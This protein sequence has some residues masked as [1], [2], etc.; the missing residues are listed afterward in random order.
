MRHF[1]AGNRVTLLTT[2][3][4][5]FP[6][7]LA[8]IQTARQEILLETY[9]FRID[10]STEPIALA[11]I[12]AAERGVSV[13]ILV[14]GFGSR[15]F[16]A[17][18]IERLRAAGVDFRFFRLARHWIIPRRNRLRRLHR[19]LAVIDG[20][21]A[22]AGGIN[23]HD[24]C[25][26]AL[27]GYAPRYD[28]AV[29]IEGPLVDAVSLTMRKLWR[30]LA[31]LHGDGWPV[32]AGP[33]SNP[34]PVGVMAARLVVRDNLRHRLSIE[35]EYLRQCHLARH[36]ILIDNAYFLPGIR[37]RRDMIQAVERGVRVRLLLQGRPDHPVMQWAT[38]SLYGQFLRAG[39]EIHEYRAGHMHA[40]VAVVDTRWATVGSSNIDPFSLGLAREANVVVDHY[41]FARE[42]QSSIL[43]RLRED[44]LRILPQMVVRAR[45]WEKW[46]AWTCY[47]IARFAINL[48]GLGEYYS[49]E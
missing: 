8:D 6:A 17:D 35:N 32:L 44:S 49:K 43:K 11:L 25:D 10:V 27:P 14:D 5:F 23:L 36:E 16:P 41:P 28:Y 13:R 4:E 9:I 22:Y 7:L 37:L 2:G 30:Q 21:Q 46:I 33:R 26:N 1:V 34:R 40:K 12:A 18:W 47:G 29:R 38:R 42:L 39:I 24:D 45:W 20:R 19:K 15:D 48:A 3:A 31:A